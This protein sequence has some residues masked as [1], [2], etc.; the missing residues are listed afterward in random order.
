MYFADPL[1]NTELTVDPGDDFQIVLNVVDVTALAGYEAMVTTSGPVTPID[2]AV[3]GTWFA[4][5]HTLFGPYE[6]GTPPAD[7][8]TAMLISPSAISGSGD[9]V[10]FT[11]H[12]DDD[13]VATI[14]L[15]PDYFILGDSTGTKMALDP[16]STISITIG[17]GGMGEEGLLGGEFLFE[18]MLEGG[19]PMGA[20][21]PLCFVK[22]DVN[23]DGKVD[24][25]DLIYVRGHLNQT[26]TQSADAY[27]CNV[28]TNANINILDLIVIRSLLGCGAPR[29][30]TSCT[31]LPLVAKYGSRSVSTTDPSPPYDSM[32]IDTEADGHT[33][34]ILSI[35]SWPAE[36]DL[37]LTVTCSCGQSC[38]SLSYPATGEGDF[39]KAKLTFD[40]A[41]S[42]SAP[43][44]HTVTIIAAPKEGAT[45][46]SDTRGINIVFNDIAIPETQD[47]NGIIYAPVGESANVS[48]LIGTYTPPEGSL[49]WTADSP[50]SIQAGQSPNAATLSSSEA[51]T[52]GV[53]V[54]YTSEQG[55]YTRDFTFVAFKAMYVSAVRPDD[56][57][58]FSTTVYTNTGVTEYH[59]QVY[60]EVRGTVTWEWEC[61]PLPNPLH[62][63]LPVLSGQ[64]TS[65]ITASVNVTQYDS[66]FAVAM[67][68]SA[69]VEAPNGTFTVTP[70]DQPTFH[71][72]SISIEIGKPSNWTNHYWTPADDARLP[73]STYPNGNGDPLYLGAPNTV[74]FRTY[75]SG[76]STSPN[77]MPFWRWSLVQGDCTL[78]YS[79]NVFYDPEPYVNY[80]VI[81]LRFASQADITLEMIA[82]GQVL[83]TYTVEALVAA[84]GPL[85]VDTF[86]VGRPGSVLEDEYLEFRVPVEN[87]PNGYT[88]LGNE[89]SEIQA[90]KATDSVTLRLDSQQVLWPIT[91]FK[92]ALSGADQIFT[93]GFP[94][95]SIIDIVA[96]S[97][98]FPDPYH[99]SPIYLNGQRTGDGSPFAWSYPS[100]GT[101]FL[102]IAV[103]GEPSRT[104]LL[105]LLR[106]PY[107]ALQ[108]DLHLWY[109][110]VL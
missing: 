16:P 103:P 83:D 51:G 59:A 8:H 30:S 44:S 87:M 23:H 90:T 55:T 47:G 6:G 64:G 101:S 43:E 89:I 41:P 13:G 69:T 105:S 73:S 25:L 17:T 93:E 42:T 46:S 63:E 29:S 65:E 52:Y 99:Q 98:E 2:S 94:A 74:E 40:H 9:L 36:Q 97:I 5:G 27:R 56:K 62:Y 67:A 66:D 24:I 84:F 22:G 96:Y 34:V 68:I 11:F 92:A 37:D 15:D 60:P 86:Y 4:S 12:A 31:A 100:A 14:D 32:W 76:L 70:Q 10:V 108:S 61:H 106:R 58:L 77:R 53:T 45:C 82:E 54:A 78:S 104:W 28:D 26:C 38:C 57:E 1:G 95:S 71:V 80:S 19:Q 110:A 49:L 109:N 48:A 79:D 75:V 35:Q 85:P 3:H 33:D 21:A 18:G 91:S 39:G 107:F 50:V 7:Y 20:E 102:A 72:P 88:V 81:G